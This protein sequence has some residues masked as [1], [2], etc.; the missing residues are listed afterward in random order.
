MAL[1]V[2]NYLNG[3][4]PEYLYNLLKATFQ[5]QPQTFNGPH[6]FACSDRPYDMKVCHTAEHNG[7][8]FGTFEHCGWLKSNCSSG[9][10]Y[11]KFVMISGRQYELRAGIF[12]AGREIA[13]KYAATVVDAA[14]T[15]FVAQSLMNWVTTRGD[16]TVLS[17]A[18]DQACIV[19]EEP[20]TYSSYRYPSKALVTNNGLERVTSVEVIEHGIRSYCDY[21]IMLAPVPEPAPSPMVLPELASWWRSTYESLID[22][23]LVIRDIGEPSASEETAAID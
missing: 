4:S 22:R 5:R 17:K 20:F 12:T 2:P 14:D 10:F 19:V 6:G 13:G 9:E 3:Q 15:Q 11:S 7:I 21:S 23:L 16:E 1:Q 18:I 8:R